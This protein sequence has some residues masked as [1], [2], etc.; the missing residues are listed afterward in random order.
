MGLGF[1]LLRPQLH[2]KLAIYC[3]ATLLITLIGPRMF[4]VPVTQ[5]FGHRSEDFAK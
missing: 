3:I 4:F 1:L 5:W 2:I